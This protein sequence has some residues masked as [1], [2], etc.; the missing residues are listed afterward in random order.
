MARPCTTNIGGYR[1]YYLC[2]QDT[3]GMRRV[4]AGTL[5]KGRTLPPGSLM[6]ALPYRQQPSLD[7]AGLLR[8]LER[9]WRLGTLDA[10]QLPPGAVVL[11][12]HGEDGMT[13]AATARMP[14][15]AEPRYTPLAPEALLGH[16]R[17]HHLPVPA[18][19]WAT[20]HDATRAAA[21]RVA[22]ALATRGSTRLAELRPLDELAAMIIDEENRDA[23][24]ALGEFAAALEALA[25]LTER[26]DPAEQSPEDRA[27]ADHLAALRAEL[28]AH[29]VEA[30]Y[31]VSLSA[32][33][34]ISEGTQV[35]G[36]P[37]TS[38]SSGPMWPPGPPAGRPSPPDP[39]SAP[40][41]TPCTSSIPKASGPGAT[42]RAPAPTSRS[43]GSASIPP[44]SCGPSR[45]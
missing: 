18:A 33:A 42:P 12:S 36:A 39:Q 32:R 20:G 25:E 1:I 8:E 9:A 26:Y 30:R 7:A 10:G 45:P 13:L 27:R 31:G 40:R 29:I 35:G 5:T 38:T 24:P 6:L 15:K 14:G 43:P 3:G 34:G 22:A 21:T 28:A 4:A 41:S 11:A 17:R 16:L 37:S 2:T 19:V 23:I 44:P